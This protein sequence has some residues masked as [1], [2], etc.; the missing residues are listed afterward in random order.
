MAREYG[1]GTW[2]WVS[3]VI[4]STTLKYVFDSKLKDSLKSE[5]GQ[6][7]VTA[8]FNVTNAVLSPNKPKPA[9]ASKR[10]ADGHEGSFCSSDKIKPLK[11]DGFQITRPKLATFNQTTL[12][13][14]LFVT[15][16]GVKYAWRRPRNTGGEVDV[17]P[18]GAQDA[19]DET[20]LV[21]G[22][23]F[24]KP[25]QGV[26]LI[27]GQGSYRCFVD[28][29]K[30]D[31]ATLDAAAASAGWSLTSPQEINVESLLNRTIGQSQG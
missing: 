30:V 25:A 20:D 26:I 28:N 13:R 24:P 22:A 18:V 23:D 19:T 8:Q 21:F 3:L 17:N 6:I 4:G 11:A 16:N 7:D 31:G 29:T 2:R 9:R 12:S 10:L 5:F 27:P 1:S 15:L 14:V